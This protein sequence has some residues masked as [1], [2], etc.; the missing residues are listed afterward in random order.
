V[1]LRREVFLGLAEGGLFQFDALAQNAFDPTLQVGGAMQA[2][3]ES[4]PG[5]QVAGNREGSGLGSFNP[6]RCFPGG[7]VFRLRNYPP[8][9]GFLTR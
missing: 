9:D 8:V 7:I 2:G 4:R 6:D 1:R 3:Q 5:R